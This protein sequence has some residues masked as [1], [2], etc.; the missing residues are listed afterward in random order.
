MKM[1]YLPTASYGDDGY[2]G[3][4]PEP[5]EVVGDAPCPCCGFITIP[6]GG[7]ALAYIC[8]VCFW[9]V[10]LFI[11]SPNEPS[12]QNH[13][14]SL[15]Q[16]REN[17]RACG[18]VLPRLKPHCRTPKERE[19]PSFAKTGGLT[20][21]NP[22][23]NC[24]LT[25][26][27]VRRYQQRPVL[28]GELEQLLEAATFAPSGSNN[29]SWLFTVIRTP[30]TLA[31][32]NL[33]VR[34]GFLALPDDPGQNSAKAAARQRAQSESFSF[35]YHAPAL[36]IASNRPGYANALPDCAAALQNIFLAAHSMGLASCWVNQLRWLEDDPALRD[37][38]AGLGLPREHVICGAAAVGY[39]QGE[40]PTAPPRKPGTVNWA[41]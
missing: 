18:A 5:P 15:A 3:P 2:R 7:D 10:D 35:Y 20:M 26:R 27:S 37:F 40:P 23:L 13:G 6:R 39:P 25:R 4:P 32:L 21:Q 38:L 9:E 16:A 30:Q 29:Q 14:L 17:V 41:D 1:P 19:H 28:Q 33:L 8:P 36:I 24:I 31:R 12:D 11:A 22:V 34:Q